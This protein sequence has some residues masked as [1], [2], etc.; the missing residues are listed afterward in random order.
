M[1]PSQKRQVI[2]SGWSVIK[3]RTH[4]SSD[5]LP[6][7]DIPCLSA[8]LLVVMLPSGPWDPRT[9]LLG[10]GQ[11]GAVLLR[12][13]LENVRLQDLWTAPFDVHPWTRAPQ[14][15][16]WDSVNHSFNQQMFI[17]QLLGTHLV[18]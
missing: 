9:E 4:R 15:G 2:L 11:G 3:V 17:E 10:R 14:T 16:T 7:C 18:R 6:I 8:A 12:H 1:A 13:S 5:L